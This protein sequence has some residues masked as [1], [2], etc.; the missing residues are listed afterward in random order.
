[1]ARKDPTDSHQNDD[2][3][4][5]TLELD[6]EGE[7]EE[8]NFVHTGSDSGVD[9]SILDGH[10][11]LNSHESSGLKKVIAKGLKREI[12]MNNSGKVF[13]NSE[14]ID[15]IKERIP[16]NN[17]DVNEGNDDEDGEDDEAG[18]VVRPEAV[19]IAGE[20]VP[21]ESL[22]YDDNLPRGEYL[23]EI[24]TPP[25]DEPGR[26]YFAVCT[27]C[28]SASIGVLHSNDDCPHGAEIV[29]EFHCKIAS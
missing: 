17:V 20:M 1:M 3:E 14:V 9:L 27:H 25:S 10:P 19:E 28:A 8:L 21:V 12:L 13:F 22:N 11:G 7:P 5:L 16:S 2:A 24:G 29:E 23:T 26:F 15:Q 18:D 4:V 6:Q